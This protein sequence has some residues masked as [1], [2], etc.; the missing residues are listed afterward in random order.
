[1]TISEYKTEEFTEMLLHD[2]N[3]IVERLVTVLEKNLVLNHPQG[4]ASCMP[5]SEGLTRRIHDLRRQLHGELVPLASNRPL[6][7]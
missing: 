5:L 4:L 1:M 2:R 7:A 3:A 6:A